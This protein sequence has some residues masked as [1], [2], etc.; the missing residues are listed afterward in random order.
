MQANA[1]D[2][3]LSCLCDAFEDYSALK[4]VVDTG[5]ASY[6]PLEN[7]ILY[8]HCKTC[9]LKTVFTPIRI[10]AM[11]G[12]KNQHSVTFSQNYDALYKDNKWKSLLKNLAYE[13]KRGLA[14]L[15]ATS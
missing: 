12:H 15:K 3:L 10:E 1:A 8:V 14:A 13:L 9:I 2:F 6:S 5:P 4:L 11:V 7:F